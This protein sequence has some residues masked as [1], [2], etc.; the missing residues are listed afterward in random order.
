MNF[1]A[2][3][4]MINK[5]LKC[6]LILLNYYFIFQRRTIEEECNLWKK[7]ISKC[8]TITSIIVVVERNV[9]FKITKDYE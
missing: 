2:N 3:A 4:F 7:Y 1:H 6:S 8:N 9:D 5:Y